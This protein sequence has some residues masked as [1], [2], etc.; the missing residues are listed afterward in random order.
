MKLMLVDEVGPM[1]RIRSD[2]RSRRCFS[3]SFHPLEWRGTRPPPAPF[4]PPA[5]SVPRK[6]LRIALLVPP[7]LS[8]GLESECGTGW[9]P[10]R[11]RSRTSRHQFDAALDDCTLFDREPAGKDVPAHHGGLP[12][13]DPSRGPD[14]AGQMPKHDQVA[15]TQVG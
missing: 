1:S 8:L 12:Q 7:A 13:F 15:N 2:S 9:R 5:V 3:I 4:V 14:I 10:T 11:C 6:R